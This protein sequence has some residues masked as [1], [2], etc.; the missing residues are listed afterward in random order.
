MLNL[1]NI[2]LCILALLNS[3]VLADPAGGYLSTFELRVLDELNHARTHP[4]QYA[5]YLAELRRSY[6]GRELRRPGELILITREGL[7]A[8]EEAIAYLETV[9]PVAGLMPSQGLSLGAAD[10]ARDQAQSGVLSHSG[11]DGSQPWER[12]NRYGAWRYSAAENISYGDN[13]ARGVVIQLLVDDGTPG[14]GHRL[15][16]FNPDY[17]FVGIA[18]GA[19][20]PYGMMCV[21]DFAAEYSETTKD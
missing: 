17:R 16:I 6:Y 4:G 10:H 21:M 13:D 12:M 5:R 3:T 7:P 18:C 11:S 2:A 1:T 9:Q 15:N 14:R 19:H 8:L 20:G